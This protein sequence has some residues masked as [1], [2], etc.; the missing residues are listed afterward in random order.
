[1]GKLAPGWHFVPHPMPLLEFSQLER[2]V[3]GPA[4]GDRG[5]FLGFLNE[6]NV[7]LSTARFQLVEVAQ[8]EEEVC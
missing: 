8:M 2:R 1:M 6:L 3:I 5:Y 4:H 7:E